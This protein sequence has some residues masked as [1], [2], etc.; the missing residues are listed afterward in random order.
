LTRRRPKDSFILIAPH[1]NFKDFDSLEEARIAAIEEYSD[2]SEVYIYKRVATGRQLSLVWDDQHPTH[3][4]H[5]EEPCNHGA[6]WDCKAQH[7]LK[8]EWCDCY[9]NINKIA[10]RM[11][12]TKGSIASQIGRML[13]V[14]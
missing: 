5:C 4:T 3:H 13:H 9:G 1:P 8:R 6:P 10:S 11:G 2:H 12:R 7:Q 14:T